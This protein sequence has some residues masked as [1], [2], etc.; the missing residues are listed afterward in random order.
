MDCANFSP[1]RRHHR[2]A[3]LGVTERRSYLSKRDVFA[4][5]ELNRRW[6]RYFRPDL[7][8]KAQRGVRRRDRFFDI[9][10]RMGGRDK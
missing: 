1:S 5:A 10:L 7:V 3:V 9:C 2:N 6:F 4:E 8:I